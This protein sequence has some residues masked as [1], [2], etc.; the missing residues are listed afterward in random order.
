MYMVPLKFKSNIWWISSWRTY[1]SY[2]SDGW[3]AHEVTTAG[4]VTRNRDMVIP[5][6]FR[7]KMTK[8]SHKA[9]SNMGNGVHSKH[10]IEQFYPLLLIVFNSFPS[11]LITIVSFNCYFFFGGSIILFLIPFF[12]YFFNH[13]KALLF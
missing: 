6:Y 13:E 9:S 1:R 4:K 7:S 2:I 10:Q 5:N 3:D 8:M 11:H 12:V